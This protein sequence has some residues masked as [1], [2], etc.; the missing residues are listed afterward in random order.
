MANTKTI[1]IQKLQA[2][3][4]TTKLIK[5]TS[6]TYPRGI[7]KKASKFT[8]KGTSDPSKSPPMKKE[9]KKHTLRMLTEKGMKKHRKTLRNRILKMSEP[10]LKEIVESKGLVRNV[11]T[12]SKI[13]REIL[14]NAV[15]AGFVSI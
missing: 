10:K 6:R 2:E 3:P 13:S 1:V 11:N 12:P 4:S 9:M 8:I 7:V 15:S 5:K 14:D